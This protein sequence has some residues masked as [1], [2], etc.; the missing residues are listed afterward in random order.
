MMDRVILWRGTAGWFQRGQSGRHGAGGSRVVGAGTKGYVT[1]H[2][3]YGKV[4]IGFEADFD[5]NT[6]TLGP[7]TIVLDGVNTIF[8][9]EVTAPGPPKITATRWTEPR[10]PLVGDHNLMMARRSRDIRDYLQCDLPMPAAPSTPVSVP[11]PPVITVC[12]KLATK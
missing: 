8:I 2:A 11:Q 3:V 10:L 4:T 5:A 9:D 12:E 1:Q 7:R 6:V